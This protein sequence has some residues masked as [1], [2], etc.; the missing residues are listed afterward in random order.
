MKHFAKF[1]ILT[2]GGLFDVLK[3]PATAGLYG[4][5]AEIR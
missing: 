2:V 4:Y 3:R 1:Y 5:S